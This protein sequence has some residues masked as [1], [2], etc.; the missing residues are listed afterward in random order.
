MVGLV[1][2]AALPQA[3][4]AATFYVDP[5]GS[6]ANPGTSQAAP[7]RSVAKVNAHTFAPGDSVLFK[8]GS[9]WN[10][11]L[12][13]RGG[14]SASAPVTVGA[15]GG[16]RAIIDGAGASGY[17]G[18]EVA[19]G[20]YV[21]YKD[22]EIR[23]WTGS[24]EQAVYVLRGSHLTFDDINA[25]DNLNGIWSSGSGS[26]QTDVHVTNSTFSGITTKGLALAINNLGS[27]GWTMTNDEFANSG[28][29]CILDWAGRDTY[30]HVRVHHC[31]YDTSV[32][33]G[34]HGFYMKGPD[35]TFKNGE[36]YDIYDGSRGGS[37]GNCISP[38]EG[39]LIENNQ[40]HDCKGVIGW[41]DYPR[42]ASQPL[43]I[44]DNRLWGFVDWGVWIEGP[45]S[46]RGD[47]PYNVAGHKV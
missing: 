9:V 16:G 37:G 26:A 47:N 13:V 3:A 44:R 30:D 43:R 14:G 17:A 5:T 27:T 4:T 46:Q 10:A 34:K 7:W 28:D 12:S 32:D 15:Y 38:R 29:S 41:F 25:H 40:L 22:L 42:A 35:I 36:I 45:N 20:D 23:N 11:M 33:Y 39:G 1:A 19:D 24:G 8:S 2:A 18:L 21:T 6:D 31:G